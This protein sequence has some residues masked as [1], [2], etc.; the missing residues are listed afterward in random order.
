MLPVVRAQAELAA[1]LCELPGVAAIAWHPARSL[2]E[3]RFFREAVLR[4]IDG[5]AF[6]GLGLAS[7]APTEDGGLKSEGLAHFTGQELYLEPALCE[8]RADAAKTA[9]RL[10]HWLVEYGHLNDI[11]DLT[12]P[13]GE[14]LKLVVNKGSA[15]VTA[16]KAAG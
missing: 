5:G 6:P 11:V 16:C 9:L 4:W 3:P 15:I 10:M 12:G 8:P 1:R 13:S 7:L 14:P 2:C